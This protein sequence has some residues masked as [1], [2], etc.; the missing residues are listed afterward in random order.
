MMGSDRL[1]ATIVENPSC[2][3]SA[4][5][6]FMGTVG[7]KLF[8]RRIVQVEFLTLISM[9]SDLKLPELERHHINFNLS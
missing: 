2:R 5:F 1:A 6:F 3:K 4:P 8:D 7:D 9:F